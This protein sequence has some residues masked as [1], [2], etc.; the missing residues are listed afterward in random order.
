MNELFSEG[1]ASSREYEQSRIRVEELRSRV[2]EAAAELTRVDV[3]LSRQ[4]EQIVRAPRN[5]V[6]LRV[7][8]GDAATFVNAGDIV[9]TFVPDNVERAVELFIDGRDVALVQPGAEVR[10]QFEGWPAVQFSGW[11]S[12]AVGTFSGRVTAVD[13]S[14]HQSGRFRVLVIKD[15]EA[16][17]P[18]PEERFVR[19]GSSARG[20]VLLDTV[21]VGYELWRLV[22]NFPANLPSSG[23]NMDPLASQEGS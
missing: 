20:W 19:F 16:D 1:L 10:L 4:S 21:P 9:A 6:I 11:P 5:G 3:N 15:P 23:S 22:N 18:W 7:N 12:L 17:S 14:A 2:A 8:A 13:P